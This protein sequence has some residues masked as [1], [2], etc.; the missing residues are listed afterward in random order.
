MP[1]DSIKANI[2]YSNPNTPEELKREIR[3]I[4]ESFIASCQKQY[5]ASGAAMLGFTMFCKMIVDWA[6]LLNKEPNP[7]KRRE[8]ERKIKGPKQQLGKILRAEC[9]IADVKDLSKRGGEWEIANTKAFIMLV[10]SM[11]EDDFRKQIAKK[12]CIK[13]KRVECDFMG[14]IR[15]LRICITHPNAMPELLWNIIA[16]ELKIEMVH[17]IMDEI[18]AMQIH[19]R[20]SDVRYSD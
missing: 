9:S 13:K 4:R 16:K 2:T 12:L 7:E 1:D 17:C 3:A 14:K 5:I 18:N 8:I 19:I 11:W 20:N 15:P 10:Y 6:E